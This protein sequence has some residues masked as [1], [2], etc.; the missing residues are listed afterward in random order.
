MLFVCLGADIELIFDWKLA[1]RV[2]ASSLT[3]KAPA[4]R[5]GAADKATKANGT[6]KSGPGPQPGAS[7]SV[8]G[9]GD[10]KMLSGTADD[11][12]GNSEV[13]DDDGAG[14]DEDSG[15]ISKTK[16]SAAKDTLHIMMTHGDLVIV[17]GGEL[18]VS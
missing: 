8:D 1:K 16:S 3:V 11:G 6:S 15:P 12:D 14:G 9:D 2:K 5:R 13:D 4:K 10:T 18:H 17:T 7:S